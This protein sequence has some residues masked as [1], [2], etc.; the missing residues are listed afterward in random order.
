MSE[1]LPEGSLQSAGTRE[2]GVGQTTADLLSDSLCTRTN[3]QVTQVET[4]RVPATGR[5]VPATVLQND[6]RNV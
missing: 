2:P 3:V 5:R 6:L 4:L 1:V